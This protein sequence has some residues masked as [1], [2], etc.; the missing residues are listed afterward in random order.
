MKVD[1]RTKKTE[2]A[3]F[4]ALRLISEDTPIAQMTVTRVAQEADITR[5]TFYDHFPT[6]VDAYQAMVDAMIER[7]AEKTTEDWRVATESRISMT[8]KEEMEL[9][10]RFF[11]G[12]VR[13]LFED[14][15]ERS[16][17]RAR[18]VT[19]EELTGYLLPPLTEQVRAGLFG[20]PKQFDGDEELVASFVLAGTLWAYRRGM[21]EGK[22]PLDKIQ[23]HACALLM[24]GLGSL[25][26]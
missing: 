6:V 11:L 1:R 20:N 5:K 14:E 25:L 8:A 15:M 21:A 18:F 10:L 16:S 4:D 24:G 9:R 7:I 22:K 17:K 26:A 12:N 23:Q 13:E 2:R 3:I 19:Q